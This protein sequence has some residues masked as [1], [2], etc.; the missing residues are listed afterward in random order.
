MQRNTDAGLPAERARTSSFGA[1]SLYL[2]GIEK[3][4]RPFLSS[5]DFRKD[6]PLTRSSHAGTAASGIEVG[7]RAA[8]E[9]KASRGVGG[10]AFAGMEGAWGG[11]DA[12]RRSRGP[13]RRVP[14][15]SPRKRSGFWRRRAAGAGKPSQVVSVEELQRKTPARLA[16]MPIYFPSATNFASNGG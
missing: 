5:L 9:E 12:A 8:A 4:I 16:S 2:G 7:R 3:A 1:H 11:S 15:G 14:K 13:A 10:G 6:F